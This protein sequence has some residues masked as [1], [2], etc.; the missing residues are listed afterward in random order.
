MINLISK[1]GHLVWLMLACSIVSCVIFLE[2][3]L[4]FHRATVNVGQ[5]L[6][7]LGNLVRRKNFAEALQHCA[8]T[9]GPVARVI[10]AAL[11]RR[12]YPR[13]HLR[14]VVQEAGQLEVPRIERTLRILLT[15]AYLA[16]LF[17]LLGTL[18]SLIDIFD[19]LQS[20]AGNPAASAAMSGAIF[21]SLISS[22]AGLVV[23]I[24]AYVFYSLL[25]SR[26]KHLLHDIERGGIEMVNLIEDSR[27]QQD[28]I[29]LP[30]SGSLKFMENRPHGRASK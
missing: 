4:Y 16:P 25:A 27:R 5:L 29:E 26:S 19:Q 8:V 13:E 3:W 2:R 7:G 18:L 28:I 15:I 22:A 14:D 1:G 30:A 17:G 21:Q 23:A 24:P 11:M 10:H 6:E 9:P 20:G 12:D